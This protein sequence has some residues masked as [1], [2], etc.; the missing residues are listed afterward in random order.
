ML[1]EALGQTVELATS[2]LEALAKAV[3]SRPEVVFLDIGMP[4]M[5]GYEVAARL[6]NLKELEP[7]RI[8][9]LT[10]LDSSEA[11]RRSAEAGFDLHLTK[12]LDPE[13]LATVL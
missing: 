12:P 2:G 13:L 4:H 10:A 8:I 1:L 5:D 3:R 11:V 9:A 7:L 6:R